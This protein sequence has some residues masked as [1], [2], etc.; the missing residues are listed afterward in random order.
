MHLKERMLALEEKNNLSNE[1]GSTKKKLE[2][3]GSQKVMDSGS[4]GYGADLLLLFSD[5]IMHKYV[6]N[7]IQLNPNA[8]LGSF[9]LLLVT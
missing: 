6:F 9:L 8:N 7:L 3:I 1:L 4:M 2:E 5:C